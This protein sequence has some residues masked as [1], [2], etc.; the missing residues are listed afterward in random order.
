MNLALIEIDRIDWHSYQCGCG[1]PAGHV[2]D[3]LRKLVSAT[4]EAQVS[5]I[6]LSNHVEIQSF[7]TEVAPAAL[8]V[9][10]AALGE[11]LH[12]EARHKIHLTL[13]FCLGGEEPVMVDGIP[14]SACEDTARQGLWQLYR[15]AA[16][17][18]GAAA[19]VINR[20]R[21]ERA[22]LEHFVSRLENPPKWVESWNFKP[23]DV[24]S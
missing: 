6:E 17:G 9:L 2:A 18:F 21:G 7:P 20:I 23:K 15:D 5:L 4:T 22:R 3:M 16:S 10:V 14:V 1:R 12:P 8:S 24:D 13:Y 11:D 19:L